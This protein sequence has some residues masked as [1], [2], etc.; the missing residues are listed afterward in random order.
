MG[1]A[2]MVMMETTMTPSLVMNSPL[3]SILLWMN[4]IPSLALAGISAIT[5]LETIVRSI[6]SAMS[7]SIMEATTK[8]KTIAW[9]DMSAAVVDVPEE[10]GVASKTTDLRE[11]THFRF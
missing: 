5:V 6:D 8:R 2:D 11:H 7:S 9:A 10:A 3:G 1:T 4:L